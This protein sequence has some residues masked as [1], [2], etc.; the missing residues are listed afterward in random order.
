MTASNRKIHPILKQVLEFGPLVAY[1]GA[2]RYFRDMPLALFGQD[3]YGLVAAMVFFVPLSIL[4]IAV[5]YALTR[6]VSRLAMAILILSVI[7]GGLTIYLNDPKYVKLRP[8][9]VNLAF[10]GIL[11]FGLYVR[12]RSYLEYLMGTLVKMSPRGWHLFTRN[13]MW[14][15]AANAVINEIIRRGFGDDIFAFWDTFGQIIL[16]FAFLVSQAPIFNR[17]AD[18]SSGKKSESKS[19]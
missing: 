6:E 19:E 5:N 15:F 10:A 16:S 1:F 9:V 12:G 8:T 14:F 17:Y 13:F 11:A 2:F 7:I 18:L 4:G 3:Y